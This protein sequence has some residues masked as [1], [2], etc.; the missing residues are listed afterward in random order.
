MYNLNFSY[1]NILLASRSEQTK[2]SL[3][4]RTLLI[5]SVLIEIKS[6]SGQFFILT[7]TMVMVMNRLQIYFRICWWW[8]FFDFSCM[9]LSLVNFIIYLLL[10][11]QEFNIPRKKYF[12]ISRPNLYLKIFIVK[13][14]SN[15]SISQN[16]FFSLNYLIKILKNVCIHIFIFK[17]CFF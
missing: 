8:F 2:F 11:R 14:H 7:V 1:R 5:L 4:Q 16:V 10:G 17:F 6:F 12:F 13:F 3:K 9:L 15:I